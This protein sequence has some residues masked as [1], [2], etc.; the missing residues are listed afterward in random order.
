MGT[1]NEDF[2]PKTFK[3]SKTLKVFSFQN[4]KAPKKRE[5]DYL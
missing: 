1:G 5:K 4:R 3:V 2:L